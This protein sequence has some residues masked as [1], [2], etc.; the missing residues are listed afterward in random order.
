MENARTHYYILKH[1]INS[2]RGG[3]AFYKFYSQNGLL[4]FS[5]LQ[6]HPETNINITT[7]SCARACAHILIQLYLPISVLL[8]AFIFFPA[9]HCNTE[10]IRSTTYSTGACS[11]EWHETKQTNG[12]NIEVHMDTVVI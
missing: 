9:T 6:S 10:L 12:R 8:P 5:T 1:L 11:S 2:L 7:N 3:R 4:I